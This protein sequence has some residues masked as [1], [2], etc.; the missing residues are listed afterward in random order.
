MN[1]KSYV[2]WIKT[3]LLIAIMGC[4]NISPKQP[5]FEQILIKSKYTQNLINHDSHGFKKM[6]FI[7]QIINNTMDS[8]SVSILKKNQENY[9]S[10]YNLTF[11]KNGIG[12][13]NTEALYCYFNKDFII[14]PPN[15]SFKLTLFCNLNTFDN[16]QSLNKVKY[17]FKNAKISYDVSLKI[18]NYNFNDSSYKLIKQSSKY[19]LELN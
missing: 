15:K 17:I 9:V 18:T 1:K 14:V 4:H 6:Y 19:S 11:P 10:Y 12:F 7:L 8:V 16:E 3:L 13:K 5:P 2:I